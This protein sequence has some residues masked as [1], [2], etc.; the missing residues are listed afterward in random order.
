M[1]FPETLPAPQN[2]SHGGNV[3]DA[4]RQY[5]IPL[6]QWLDLSTGISPFSY[7]VEGIQLSAFQRLP[8]PDP[9][10]VQAAAD[11]YGNDQL[12][13]V[14]GSQPVIQALPR[15]L[16]KAPVLVPAL[17]YQEHGLQW[18]QAGCRTD[19]YP[20]TDHHQARDFLDRALAQDNQRHL[21]IINPNNPTGL[22]FSPEQIRDWARRLAPD[23]YLIV[24]E[25]FIDVHPGCSVLPEHFDE[26]LIVLRSFGKFFGL[27]GIR[28]GFVFANGHIRAALG[29]EMGIWSINGPAQ[30]IALKALS[31][32][33][34][35]RLAVQR[36]EAAALQAR[37]LYA[38]FTTRLNATWSV[39]DPLFSTYRLSEPLAVALQDHFAR[40][41][42]LIRRIPVD[43]EAHLIR[44]G[45][46]DP[47]DQDSFLRVHQTIRSFQ[48]R[49]HPAHESRAPFRP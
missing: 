10:L 43:R 11:Y 18:R 23:R 44:V 3:F 19:A 15:I 21:L 25:A 6:E 24:D 49:Y 16:P 32:S 8:Y 27:A 42:V 20:S 46:L 26:S 9:R 31:D 28:L 14:P 5:G 12:L 1:I 48:V 41:G 33:E 22:R 13:P 36:I 34:W 35:Q 7:P 4:S 40:L 2:L 29:Q 38:P 47:D 30:A 37:Q 39:H 17:G 45:R